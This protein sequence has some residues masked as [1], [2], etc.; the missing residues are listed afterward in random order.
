MDVSTPATTRLDVV[1]MEYLECESLSWE[2]LFSGFDT[3]HAE[4]ELICAR[5]VMDSI[6]DR[7]GEDVSTLPYSE[8]SFKAVVNIAIS[9]VFFSWVFGFSGKVKINSPEP[10]KERYAEMLKAAVQ[11]LD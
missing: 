6:I 1:K 4:V 5:E 7:F 8:N 2:E 11:S 3:L 10:V 9:N